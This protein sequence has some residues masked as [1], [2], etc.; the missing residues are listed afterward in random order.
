MGRWTILTVWSGLTMLGVMVFGGLL[1]AGCDDDPGGTLEFGEVCGN[2][3]ECV[4]EICRETDLGGITKRCSMMCDDSNPCVSGMC[5]DSGECILGPAPIEETR[6]GFIYVGPVGDHGWTKAHD[7]G[8]VHLEEHASNIEVETAESIAPPDAPAQIERFIEN[9]DNVIIGCSHDFLNPLQEAATQHPDTLFLGVAAFENSHNMGSYFGRI[10]QAN[11]LIGMAAGSATTTNV[12]G[13]VGPVVFG[14]TVLHANAFAR[15]VAATNPDAEVYIEWIGNWF[16]TGDPP[17]EEVAVDSLVIDFNADIIFGRTDTPIPMLRVAAMQDGDPENGE[18]PDGT[19]TVY[20]VGF[21]NEDACHFSP[22]VC[23]SSAYW[24]WGPM[25][26]NIIQDIQNGDYLPSQIVWDQ[27]REDPDESVV[28]FTP[29]N[30]SIVDSSIISQINALI[31]LAAE[32]SDAGRYLAF[33]GPVVDANGDQ[34]YAAGEY[35]TDDE[36][37]NMCWYVENLRDT[38]ETPADVP[39]ECAGYF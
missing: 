22:D 31:P 17:E 18:F 10:Y 24:N 23:I 26:T 6:I 12:I 14:E 8:R 20:T 25:V 2:D 33:E 9:G 38:D 4:S 34:R 27:M 3:G 13:I 30:D 29:I 15:G 28:Y 5:G 16:S 21:D 1:L 11:Y 36:L 19:P 35:P 39:V 7:D 37:W 32:D